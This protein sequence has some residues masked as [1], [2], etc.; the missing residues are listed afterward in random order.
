MPTGAAKNMMRKVRSI[1]Q[2]SD[3]SMLGSSVRCRHTLC[4]ASCKAR[5]G[6]RGGDARMRRESEGG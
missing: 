5:A 6:Q 2:K 4:P 3:V 1:I